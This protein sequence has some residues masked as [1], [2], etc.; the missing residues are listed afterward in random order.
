VSETPEERRGWTGEDLSEDELARLRREEDV[1]FNRTLGWLKLLHRILPAAKWAWISDPLRRRS[2]GRPVGPVT[3]T[4]ADLEAGVDR[5]RANRDRLTQRRLAGE[6]HI[7]RTTLTD[8]LAAH[9]E[10]WPALVARS[11]AQ[12]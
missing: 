9:P 3:F 6:C 1:A 4:V 5:I 8:Y 12:K 11:R 2:P 7:G 10:L